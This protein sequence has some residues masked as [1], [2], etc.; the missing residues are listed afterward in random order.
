VV[1]K[2][3]GDRRG[4][5]CARRDHDETAVTL[6]VRVRGLHALVYATSG[7]K[8]MELVHRGFKAAVNIRRCADLEDE[9]CGAEASE[10]LRASL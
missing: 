3:M 1:K 5:V 10:V 4:T 9:P 2:K 6:R 8:R 7:N